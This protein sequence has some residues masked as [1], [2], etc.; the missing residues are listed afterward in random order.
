MNHLAELE[1]KF[2]FLGEELLDEIKMHGIYKEV[3]KGVQI[4]D[5]GD[6][7]SFIPILLKGLVKVFNQT[8]GKRLLL[9]YVKEHESCIVGF[10][11]YM[12]K[13]PI[14]VTGV[15]EEDSI[16]LLLPNNKLDEWRIKYPILI[17]EL[18]TKLYGNQYR[19][20]IDNTCQLS[21]SKLDARIYNYLEERKVLKNQN[22]IKVTHQQIA[23]DLA[24]SREVVSRLVKKMEKEGKMRQYSGKIELFS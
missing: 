13:M 10:L 22:P 2:T 20:L 18:F 11:A 23:N 24:T 8:N 7:I 9:Y 5:K 6:R 12:T 19:N 15:T 16:L 21:F 3:P 14:N 4:A 1:K 17:N